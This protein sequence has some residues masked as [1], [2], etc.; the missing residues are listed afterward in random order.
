VRNSSGRIQTAR[1]L[2]DAQLLRK[3]CRK[4]A[5]LGKAENGLKKTG[6]CPSEPTY[7]GEKDRLTRRKQIFHKPQ[8]IIAPLLVNYQVTHMANEIYY[9]PKPLASQN[10]RDTKRSS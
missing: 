10:R 9:W 1:A 6:M 5:T 2:Q 7:L 8:N 3:V 4:A